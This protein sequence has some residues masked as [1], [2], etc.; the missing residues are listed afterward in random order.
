[1]EKIAGEIAPETPM[2]RVAFASFIGT[3]I[4]FYDF[5]IYGLAAALVFPALFFPDL[6]PV[7]GLLASFATYGVAFLARPLGGAIFGHYGDRI[8]RKAM[9]I[10]SLLT[11]GLATFLVGLLPGYAQI[12]ILAPIL[13]VVL[14]F[15]QGIGLGGEW[16]GAVLMAAEH[17]PPGRRAFYSGFPQVG[18]ALGYLLSAG[19]FLLLVSTLSQAQFASWGWR[20]PF[21]VSI[22]LVGVG[23]FIRARLAETPVFR[24]VME[25]RTEARV[26]I[27][28]VL[29]AYPKTVVFASLAGTLV[30]AFFYIVTVFSVSYGVTQLG[31]P[32]STMLYCVMVSV[33]FMG[34]G[35]LFFATI[36]DRVGRR[37]LALLS[38]GFLGLWAFPMFWLVDTADPILI[39]V[40]F[41]VGLFAWSATYGP[42]GA[43]FSELFGTRVRYSGSS[44]SYALS[45]VLGAALA[46][47]IAVR[48]LS[49]T[50]ASW[51]V[52][53][54]L[55]AVALVSLVSILL[56]SETYRTDLSATRPEEHQL[57]AE[58]R[59]P[60]TD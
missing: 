2:S 3:M 28:D 26:P 8:G 50:G 21:L 51:S 14:R 56:L 11:M 52:S 48:L 25:T 7:S 27:L 29:R 9:L 58:S 5:Y 1:M 34:V 20:I 33:V 24:R 44:L 47:L 55:F 43:F 22:V 35:I 49:A 17:A 53:L 6:S 12:G 38:S 39:T 45:G 37:N 13:L 41:S 54:Y 18:P 32:Q 59:E 60:A 16:G 19:I 42:M 15:L 4:E 23:L 36:S 46:P 30:F 57:I 40:A 10:V 31:L